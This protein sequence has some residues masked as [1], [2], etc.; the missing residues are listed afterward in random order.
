MGAVNFMKHNTIK[1]F[2][3][4]LLIISLFF[5]SNINFLQADLFNYNINIM[6]E[7]KDTKLSKDLAVKYGRLLALKSVVK[8]IILY[9]DASKIDKLLNIDN[10]TKFDEGFSLKNE[11]ITNKFYFAYA[12]YNFSEKQILSFL[13]ENN[14]PYVKNRLSKYI[15]II[16]SNNLENDNLWQQ[17]WANVLS[18]DYL[19]T[20]IVYI[21]N[22][23]IQQDII[24][25]SKL[26]KQHNAKDIYELELIKNDILYELNIKNLKTNKIMN[27]KNINSI[28][29]AISTSQM[30]IEN[31]E[32]EQIIKV[33]NVVNNSDLIIYTTNFN[34]WVFIQTKLN[35]IEN[36]KFMLKEVG[37][38]YI[39]ININFKGNK[40]SLAHI[41]ND[42]C[43]GFNTSQDILFV[44]P[45]C[46]S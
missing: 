21:F 18:K 2:S 11:N 39:K 31:N 19:S 37:N 25:P 27:F 10:A 42:Y 45:D 24:N 33:N 1:Q 44:M 20:F 46:H 35:K 3:F 30:M 26:L 22:K 15:L 12:T 7:S 17:Y 36:L 16:K 32:K 4:K 5:T 8:K 23:D 29:L 41:L 9:Q 34:D 14:I 6:Y 13:D 43:V 38:D 28:P 40:D